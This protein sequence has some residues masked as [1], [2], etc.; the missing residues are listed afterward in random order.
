PKSFY[1]F[2]NRIARYAQSKESRN[3]SSKIPQITCKAIFR[4]CLIKNTSPAGIYIH[5][6]YRDTENG[7]GIVCF[8]LLPC[9]YQT[10]KTLSR[11]NET[12]INQRHNKS[13]T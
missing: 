11:S 5:I 13:T 9:R 1:F 8:L 10:S 6:I 7:L 4:S 2:F 12:T 3:L